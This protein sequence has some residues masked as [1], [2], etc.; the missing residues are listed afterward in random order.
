MKPLKCRRPIRTLSVP[1][2]EL[3]PYGTSAPAFTSLL[4]HRRACLFEVATR[5]DSKQWG[6]KSR[7]GEVESGGAHR[8]TSSEAF[9]QLRSSPSTGLHTEVQSYERVH[10]VPCKNAARP[11]TNNPA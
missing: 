4:A 9:Q 11:L 3:K 7:A 5:P 10:L 1:L 6:D 8:G 2:N